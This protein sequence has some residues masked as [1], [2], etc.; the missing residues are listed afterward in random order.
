MHAR[1]GALALGRARRALSSTSTSPP[2]GGR[3]PFERPLFESEILRKTQARQD[4][5]VNAEFAGDLVV[6]AVATSVLARIGYYCVYGKKS[7]AR[8]LP[9]RA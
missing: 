6:I 8:A 1:R 7:G 9:P 3:L 2:A 5:Q 4:A